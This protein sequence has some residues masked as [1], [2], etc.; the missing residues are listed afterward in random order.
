MIPI[1]INLKHRTDRLHH[2]RDAWKP[3]FSKLNRFNAYESNVRHKGTSLSHIY[4]TLNYFNNHKNENVVFILEDDAIPYNSNI[5]ELINDFVN[6]NNDWEAIILS[7]LLSPGYLEIIRIANNLSYLKHGQHLSTAAILYNRRI[8]KYFLELKKYYE[9]EKI[10]YI[11]IDSKL[12]LRKETILFVHENFPIVKQNYNLK[13]DNPNA[14]SKQIC[15]IT[16]NASNLILTSSF[17]GAKNNYY[18]NFLLGFFN[19]NPE[20]T[21]K[22]MYV[23]AIYLFTI[24]FIYVMIKKLIFIKLL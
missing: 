18:F 4:A 5:K 14:F 11:G 20:Y 19:L 8:I 22:F 21:D 23:N 9:S 7:S 1:I 13:S 12:S 10:S 16:Q 24:V 15:N 2:T 3:M 17:Y 6:I